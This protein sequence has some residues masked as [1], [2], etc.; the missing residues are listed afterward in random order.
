MKESG[1]SSPQEENPFSSKMS[2]YGTFDGNKLHSVYVPGSEMHTFHQQAHTSFRD[3]V[4]KPDFACI[5]GQGAARGKRYAFNAYPDMTSPAVAEGISHDL[6]KFKN[7]FGLSDTAEKIKLVS[8]VTVFKEPQS[9][10]QLE[11]AGNLYQLLGNMHEQD[12][13][14]GYEWNQSVSKDIDSPNFGFSSGGDA[15]FITYLYPQA[16]SPA[17]RS[18]VPLVLFTAHKIFDELKKTTA[19]DKLKA[20]TRIREGTVH[21]HSGDHGDVPEFRQY[22][23]LDP[24]KQIQKDNEQII[25]D[26]L[27]KCPFGY[28]KIEDK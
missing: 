1:K 3:M 12:K 26:K 24:D 18:E 5:A 16:A 21:P 7:E 15:F 19:F 14:K 28:D 9:G 27:G 4:L 13:Q 25:Y 8:F 10:T 20:A 22:A 17:R 2:G 11:G 6:L 23:L